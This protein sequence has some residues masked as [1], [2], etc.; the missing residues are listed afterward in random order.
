M[1]AAFLI[2]LCSQRMLRPSPEDKAAGGNGE[3]S[4]EKERRPLFT[5]PRARYPWRGSLARSGTIPMTRKGTAS[6]DSDF[7]VRDG[8]GASSNAAGGRPPAFG[9]VDRD[10]ELAQYEKQR[11]EDDDTLSEGYDDDEAF[12]LGLP[13]TRSGREGVWQRAT[14]G[15]WRS[16]V[17]QSV[18]L[19]ATTYSSTDL[20]STSGVLCGC[21]RAGK[22][23]VQC[24]RSFLSV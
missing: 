9:A 2:G 18:N 22:R 14:S 13:G 21:R 1:G 19:R 6:A 15:A 3:P 23:S 8:R 5:P 12:I 20:L 11:P 4:L 24:W 10:G 17:N 16:V 7:D